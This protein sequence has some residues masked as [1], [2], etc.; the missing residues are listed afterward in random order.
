MSVVRVV[1]R[2]P[3]FCDVCVVFVRCCSSLWLTDQLYVFFV[4]FCSALFLNYMLVFMYFH[5][6]MS[7]HNIKGLQIYVHEVLLCIFLTLF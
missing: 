4:H 5:H 3:E 1:A 2:A 6:D 7:V